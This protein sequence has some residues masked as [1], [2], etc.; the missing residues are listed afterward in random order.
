MKSKMQDLARPKLVLV[1]RDEAAA[2]C[3]RA[4]RNEGKWSPKSERPPARRISLR[5]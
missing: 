1:V 4:S 3:V 2:A 5:V